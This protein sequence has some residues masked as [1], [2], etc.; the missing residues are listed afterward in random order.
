MSADSLLRGAS[1][2]VLRSRLIVVEAWAGSWVGDGRVEGRTYKGED[3]LGTCQIPDA[4]PNVLH[5]SAVELS[6]ASY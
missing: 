6:R 2:Q 5:Y 1:G 3:I 4:L